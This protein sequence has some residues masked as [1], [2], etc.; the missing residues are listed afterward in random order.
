MICNSRSGRPISCR[1]SPP[2]RLN[3]AATQPCSDASIW[4]DF[5]ASLQQKQPA[6]LFLVSD[7]SFWRDFL[8]SGQYT[9]SRKLSSPYRGPFSR[10]G[11]AFP[12]PS[13]HRAP[14]SRTGPAFSASSPYIS[15]FSRTD[16]SISIPS[17]HIAPSARTGPSISAPSPHRPPFSRT[18][19]AFSASSPYKAYLQGLRRSK[20]LT[21]S[22]LRNMPAVQIQQAYWISC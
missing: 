16:P 10:T 15:P 13:P 4:C 9:S 12:I 6:A 20:V 19:P 11:P 1:N 14:F 17:P 5:L 8:A 22:I 3:P 2:S 7:A 21:D 18:G